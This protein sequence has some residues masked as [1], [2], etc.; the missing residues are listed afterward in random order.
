[1]AYCI[2]CQLW[3]DRK[4]I[5]RAGRELKFEN[6]ESVQHRLQFSGIKRELKCYFIG[7]LISLCFCY[8]PYI[9]QY[10]ND[11]VVLKRK[12]SFLFDFY[13][14]Q[15]SFRLSTIMQNADKVLLRWRFLALYMIGPLLNSAKMSTFFF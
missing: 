7:T 3:R 4:I 2:F 5:L 11:Y 6:Y 15:L 13:V 14:M 8:L 12:R 9:I 1:M 10:V